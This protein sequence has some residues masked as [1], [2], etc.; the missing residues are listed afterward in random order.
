MGY[1][2]ATDAAAWI[3]AATGTLGLL[4]DVVKWSRGGARL[5]VE[6]MPGMAQAIGTKLGA[7]QV[8]G[9]FVFI[10]I[11]NVGDQSATISEIILDCYTGWFMRLLRRPATK[12]SVLVT[13]GLAELP[14]RIEPGAT[15]DGHV[16]QTR[17][18]KYKHHPILILRV[19]YNGNWKRVT[20]RVTL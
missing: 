4:W 14:Y 17:F 18:D 1:V 20:M 13:G 15:W 5:L 19:K 16:P 6:F 3:G 10:R 7:V 2:N 8:P 9:L 12:Y 11:A